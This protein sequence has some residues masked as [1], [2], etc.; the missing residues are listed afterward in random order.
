MREN[1]VSDLK[2]LGLSE[3]EARAYLALTT[4]GPL[5]ASS[6]SSFSR[7]PQ[8]KIYE[9][10]KSLNSKS[11]ADFWSGKPLRYRAIEPPFA[12]KRMLDQKKMKIDI[13][14]EKT[15]NLIRELKPF[16]EAG[17]SSWSSKGKDAYHEKTAEIL[18]RSSAFG[19]STT[20]NF[21]RHPSLDEEFVKAKKRGVKIRMLGTSQMNDEK[22]ARAK[23]YARHGAEI[24]ILPLDISATIGMIDDK[25][26]CIRLDNSSI[27]SDVLWTNNPSLIVVLKAYFCELW[28]RAKK[29]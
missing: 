13:L 12:L 5:P 29:F 15:E 24:R 18:S 16:K 10:L 14:R 23:W 25:E 8:S 11:L 1:I 19:F 28:K 20:S 26:V 21:S 27:D 17:F 6:V 7:I 22:T 3:Y 4:H 9:V 2:D